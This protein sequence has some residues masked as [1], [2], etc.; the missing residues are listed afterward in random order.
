VNVAV[1]IQNKFKNITCSYASCS[2]EYRNWM[3]CVNVVYQIN[4]RKIWCL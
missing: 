4:F 2:F 3:L 1:V